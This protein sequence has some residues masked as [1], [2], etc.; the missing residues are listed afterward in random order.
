MAIDDKTELRCG[1]PDC[2]YERKNAEE[3]LLGIAHEPF[4]DPCVAYKPGH[5]TTTCLKYV[6]YNPRKN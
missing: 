2:K 3:R 5:E 1:H 4:K 6:K